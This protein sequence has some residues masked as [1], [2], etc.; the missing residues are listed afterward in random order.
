[1]TDI[2]FQTLKSTRTGEGASTGKQTEVAFNQNFALVKRLLDELFTIAA[3]TV[4]S[5]QITQIKADTTTTPYTLYYT[6]DPLDSENPTWIPLVSTS[7]ANLRGNPNDNIALKT[8]LDSKGSAN[9]VSILQTQMDG[10]TSNI[11]ALQSQV[12]TNTSDIATNTASISDI[13]D[14]LL[15]VVH[16]QHG[17][18]LYIRYVPT[19]NTLEYSVDGTTYIDINALGTNF[20]SITGNV[21]DNTTLVTYIATEITNAVTAATATYALNEDLRAHV[22]NIN[23]PHNVTKA[24]IGL[25]NVENYSLATMPIPASVQA[26]LDELYLGTVPLVVLTPAEYQALTNPD[27]DKLYLTNST[28]N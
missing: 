16:T 21:E 1:M 8:I 22:T 25:G 5:E 20:S 4:T 3:I 9:D 28:Y 10:A 2:I 19:T 11:T 18:T 12:G 17:D 24:Q 27:S 14:E 7:F 26:A 15:D 6:I 13:R 23:N